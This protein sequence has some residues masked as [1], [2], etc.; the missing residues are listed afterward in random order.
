[1]VKAKTST[2]TT[3][4]TPAQSRKERWIR[5]IE[6][7]RKAHEAWRKRAKRA[8]GAYRDDEESRQAGQKP[9]LFP[10][11]WATVQITVGAIFAN[12]PKPDVRRRW[13][14]SDA[15]GDD[16]LAQ[17]IERGLSFTVDTTGFEDHA[18][19][20]VVDYS[21]GAC[22]IAKIELRTD[23]I[24][25]PVIDPI[26][27]QPMAGDDG[28][29]LT[30]KLIQRQS[31]H[32]RHFHWSK[33]GWEPGKDWEHVDWEYFVH[34]MTADEIE[35]R[36]DV[37]LQGASD[38]PKASGAGAKKY[39]QTLEV[40]EI[41]NR[42][43]REVLFVCKEYPEP[44]EVTEDPLRLVDFYPNPRPLLCNVSTKELVPKP[45]YIEVESQCNN[46]NV[47][48]GRIQSLTKQ[49][50]DVG[51]YDSQLGE[52]AKLK[53]APDGTRVPIKN[54]LERLD[55]ASKADFD[56]VLATQDNT[57]RV[58]VLQQLLQQR[59]AEKGVIYETLGISD[60]VRGATIATE[61][62]EAQKLKSQWANVRIGPKMKAIAVFFRDV[63]RIMAEIIAEH[64]DQAQ[65]E[66]MTGTKLG[67]EQIAKLRD[68]LARAY[69]VDVET[70][71]T[72][73]VDDAEER[74]QRLEVVKAM[75]DYLGVYL[76]LAQQNL[77][78]ASTVKQTLLFVIRSFKY[79][80]ELEEEIRQMPD[81]VSQL[82]QLAGQLQ[83]CQ[84][85]LEQASA[86]VQ[87]LSS[88][89]QQAEQAKA[90]AEAKAAAKPQDDP[91]AIDA[92]INKTTAETDKIRVE[93]AQLA[94]SRAAE[95]GVADQSAQ[96]MQVTHQVVM[97]LGQLL[98]E[99]NGT[100]QQLQGAAA[101]VA[102]PK[103][104][105]ARMVR[106]PDGSYEAEVTEVP[107]GAG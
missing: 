12:A 54:L 17:A 105:R 44:L 58:M 56:Q 67:P 51:F 69:A 66:R 85:Q 90:D 87:Q 102:T 33:F 93:T 13:T 101:I 79:G 39:Q 16:Q 27:K 28:E 48:T 57:G 80:R 31:V 92:D 81:T 15:P 53:D 71:S 98:N 21:V 63:F 88:D 3:E 11:F 24:E 41:W 7:E 19:L 10:I 49:I 68:D 46:I 100:L 84:Q 55:K 95:S 26:T 40:Y 34:D 22:G 38:E 43:K 45:D 86:Q 52:L 97:A 30:Q 104:K 9:N 18:R 91:R 5:R 47:L 29:P 96:A 32:L 36:W 73:A 6:R 103:S 99:V 64:F 77:I 83:Q 50:K 65:L 4:A 23:T 70:D 8:E 60:I 78:P 59:E 37:E 76:P 72:L 14:G 106:L 42:A 35:D 82:Q 61:T 25:A 89:L 74:Q 2:K 20:A 75:T 1:V 94:A 62:A 107:E